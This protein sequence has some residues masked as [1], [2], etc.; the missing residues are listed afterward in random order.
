[1]ASVN[2]TDIVTRIQADLEGIQAL[3]DFNKNPLEA[4]MNEALNDSASE[5]DVSY[6]EQAGAG[7]DQMQAMTQLGLGSALN[8]LFGENS[9]SDVLQRW[10]EDNLRESAEVRTEMLEDVG[11]S[12]A[13]KW[14]VNTFLTQGPSTGLSI[15]ATSI[16][17]ILGFMVFGPPG[18]VAGAAGL[19]YLTN[20][21]LNAGENN[22]SQLM[23]LGVVDHDVALAAGATNAILDTIIPYKVGRIVSGKL[24]PKRGKFTEGFNKYVKKQIEEGSA[25]AS[26][27]GKGISWAL[28][29]G[30]TEGLQEAINEMFINYLKEEPI[31]DF[32]S[33]EWKHIREAAYAGGLVFGGPLG[34]LTG[35]KGKAAGDETAT[36]PPAPTT[37]AGFPVEPETDEDGRPIPRFYTDP[38]DGTNKRLPDT[39]ETQADRLKILN[40]LKYMEDSPVPSVPA[41]GD[42]VRFAGDDVLA[43]RLASL[44]QTEALDV[45]QDLTADQ[46]G[47]YFNLRDMGANHRQ[48]M[49][50]A[51]TGTTEFEGPI[52]PVTAGARGG[53]EEAASAIPDVGK[54]SPINEAIPTGNPPLDVSVGT[55]T[56]FPR[57]KEAMLGWN[58]RRRARKAAVEARQTA[59]EDA[60]RAEA[61]TDRAAQRERDTW[62][63][64][65]EMR[66][67][68]DTAVKE[69]AQTKRE[70]EAEF[71]ATE[72]RTKVKDAETQ[73]HEVY[74]M[75]E[76]D[77][78]FTIKQMRA[79]AAAE[80]T[81]FATKEEQAAAKAIF[82]WR[83]DVLDAK[84][85]QAAIMRGEEDEGIVAPEAAPT[86]TAEETTGGAAEAAAPTETQKQITATWKRLAE[87]KAKADQEAAT[88][89]EGDKAPTP[90]VTKGTVE[91]SSEGLGLVLLD[92]VDSHV[93]RYETIGDEPGRTFVLV[94]ITG[95][96]GNVIE[97]PFYISTGVGGKEET[98]PGKWYPVLGIGKADWINKTTG[99]ELADYYG[100]P[101]LREAAEK[102][103]ATL[104]DIRDTVEETVDGV[105]EA[106]VKA[107]LNASLEEIGTVII[108]KVYESGTVKIT[109]TEGRPDRISQGGKDDTPAINI[110]RSN[111]N[112]LKTALGVEETTGG[113][114]AP[115]VDVVTDPEE[116]VSATDETKAAQEAIAS[117]IDGD[118]HFS[119]AIDNLAEALGIENYDA[120]RLFGSTLN[121][122]QAGIITKKELDS[123]QTQE[124]QIQEMYDNDVAAA[125]TAGLERD[126][127]AALEKGREDKGTPEPPSTDAEIDASKKKTKKKT[128]KKKKGLK[129]AVGKEAKEGETKEDLVKF[130]DGEG[131]SVATISNTDSTVY[132]ND[133]GTYTAEFG[134]TIVPEPFATKA[135]AQNYLVTEH[136]TPDEIAN[137]KMSPIAGFT[138]KAR[139]KKA[140]KAAAKVDVTKA[141][142]KERGKFDKGEFE[143]NDNDVP[144]KFEDV[145]GSDDRIIYAELDGEPVL[146]GRRKNATSARGR[147]R[148]INLDAVRKV[149]RNLIKAREKAEAQAG[150]EAGVREAAVAAADV[151]TKRVATRSITPVSIINM[152]KRNIL[153]SN[154]SDQ[155]KKAIL[156]IGDTDQ[157]VTQK[158]DVAKAILGQDT[159]GYEVVVNYP[160]AGRQGTIRPFSMFIL[161]TRAAANAV[162]ES[163]VAQP[164]LFQ[165]FLVDS[166]RDRA[167]L[168]PAGAI[169]S[170]EVA[171]RIESRRNSIAE[172][173]R[174]ERRARRKGNS[175]S[176]E[177]LSRRDRYQRELDALMRE[178][179][180][181]GAG[182]IVPGDTVEDYNSSL[183]AWIAMLED[184]VTITGSTTRT[185]LI[186]KTIK[187]ALKLTEDEVET[188]EE[189]D[190]EGTMADE[191]AAVLGGIEEGQAAD[192]A[193]AAAK[194]NEEALK[195]EAD[196]A[197]K[198]S[199]FDK[200]KKDK[201]K[202]KE[203][204]EGVA[205]DNVIPI[206]RI[207]DRAEF[208]EALD[209]FDQNIRDPEDEDFAL[210]MM[211]QEEKAET[212]MAFLQEG[213]ERFPN[214][215]LPDSLILDNGVLRVS[216]DLVPA[217]EVVP[218]ETPT[219]IEGGLETEDASDLFLMEDMDAA[220]NEEI[221][222]Q[223]REEAQD[224]LDKKNKTTADKLNP[225]AI[226]LEDSATLAADLSRTTDRGGYSATQVRQLAA[227]I[228]KAFPEFEYNP[229]S[230][231]SEISQSVMSWHVA[232]TTAEADAVG[233]AGKFETTENEE[234][235]KS[236]RLKDVDWDTR[237]IIRTR[238]DAKRSLRR[239]LNNIFG[240][241]AVQRMERIGFINIINTYRDTEWSAGLDD[242]AFVT[243]DRGQV[244][245]I[246]DGIKDKLPRTELRG[247]ILHEIGVHVGRDLFTGREWAQILDEVYKL[248]LEGNEAVRAAVKKV[249][250]NYPDE[251][252][253]DST[254]RPL[255]KFDDS[256]KFNLQFTKPF[257]W[258][259]GE[260]KTGELFRTAGR[261]WL[262]GGH[263]EEFKERKR[264]WEEV[265]AHVIDGD[266]YKV[267][268][269]NASKSKSF[270]KK[271]KEAFNKFF[272]KV[273]TNFGGDYQSETANV[274]IDDV[275]S[276]IGYAITHAPTLALARHGDPKAI[277][278][279][280]NLTRK[281]FLENSQEKEVQYHGTRDSWSHPLIDETELGLH[282]GT[283]V[284]AINIHR[285][286]HWTK[287]AP[288]RGPRELLE[289][290]G[291]S[292]V[293]IDIFEPGWESKL[294]DRD[295]ANVI[296]NWK[297]PM[298][299][300]SYHATDVVQTLVKRGTVIKAGYVKVENPL[301]IDDD[302]G[303]W[304]A[305]EA[306][307]G[308][309]K[310]WLDEQGRQ[311]PAKELEASPLWSMFQA[312]NELSTLYDIKFLKALQMPDP[313]HTIDS[314]NKRE[315]MTDEK[316]E[317]I[318]NVPR[319]FQ[320]KLKE[321]I[322]KNGYDSIAY[323]NGI[324]DQG[325]T[326]YIL[327]DANQFM[328]V[329][330]LT[331]KSGIS[332]F[333][334]KKVITGSYE[335]ELTYAKKISDVATEETAKTVIGNAKQFSVIRFLQ[336]LVE[337]LMTVEGYDQLET[338]RMLTKGKIGQW[339]TTGRIL[340]DIM[341]TATT[342]E[343]KIITKFFTTRGASPSMLPD[344]QV[345]VATRRTILKG[346]RPG[347]QRNTR[348]VSLRDEVVK[349]KKMISDLGKEL[350]S[351]GMITK[352]QYA[353]W[354]NKYLP[355]IYLKNVLSGA[356]RMGLGF[357]SSPL[358][359]T[360]QRK[361]ERFL[362]DIIE[363]RIDDPALLASRYIQMAGS[364]IAVM[365][366][367]EFIVS[368]PGNNGWVLPGQ[369]IKVRGMSGTAPY[370]AELADAMSTRADLIDKYDS[371]KANQA[372]KLAKEMRIKADAAM[373]D[374]RGV[375]M[376][377]YRQ[378][379]KSERYGQMQGLWVMKDIWNDI[380][381]NSG[382]G[383]NSVIMEMFR[384]AQTG[385]KYTHVPLNIPTQFRN[386]GSN[387]ILMDT[388]GTNFLKIPGLLSKAVV[389]I[390]HNGKYHQIAQKYGL[391]TTTFAS[392][393]LLRIDKE[394]AKVQ[395]KE[396][397]IM[398][399]MAKGKI[400]FDNYIDIGGRT[401]QASEVLFKTAKIMDLM[402][403]HGKTEAEAARLANEALIDYSNVSV[404]IRALRSL[405]LGSPF[406]TFNAKVTAQLVRNF[407]NHPLSFAKYVALPW[408]VREWVLS[409]NDDLD[410]EDLDDLKKFLHKHM[411]E[412]KGT[413]VMPTKDHNG[414][415]QVIPFN[416]FAPWGF[417]LNFYN[418]TRGLFVEDEEARVGEALM[419]D[420][421]I[422][423][424]PAEI[425]FGLA[426]NV[427]PFTGHEIWN[428]FDPPTQQYQDITA[429]LASYFV[430]PMLM[431]RNRAGDIVKGG[432]PLVKTMMAYNYIE[433]N[434]GQDGLPKYTIPQALLSWMGVNITTV[435][436]HDAMAKAY[437]SWKEVENIQRRLL[438]IITDPSLR[439]QPSRRLELIQ[440]YQELMLNKSLEAQE[441][442][443]ALN[444]MDKLFNEAKASRD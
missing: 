256:Q 386:V 234:G 215:T 196:E 401:Y 207:T 223:E 227:N 321:L 51:I 85:R 293:E 107:Q 404:G 247:L 50:G 16:G 114:P 372:R 140:T 392:E 46:Q 64:N 429:Y 181:P 323:V 280:R 233:D 66:Q 78:G 260:T 316:A 306:W 214:V 185:P 61:T 128:T 287:G 182:V 156:S 179:N 270:I 14:W 74:D 272:N 396:N 326:S 343:R 170:E 81:K 230:V 240:S 331:F 62:F 41:T 162:R 97:V 444:K 136:G 150:K 43:V 346:D 397:S 300:K 278:K 258:E 144:I 175:I 115:T 249:I 13:G 409:E 133:D 54:V 354:E 188:T 376:S 253:R 145:R 368:D 209:T 55:E 265:L 40:Q 146:M 437:Y 298:T 123:D 246:A 88:R 328:P 390:F 284:V 407:K 299:F 325:S 42:T 322:L 416:Y 307:K 375:D 442:S 283:P 303:S 231:K 178:E 408:I 356:D 22:A 197:A 139:K 335:E 4:S 263:L 92:G 295:L 423:S 69:D 47:T 119:D 148:E 226:L 225:M 137:W 254:G 330:S 384:Y 12:N 363:G 364:D 351:M 410:E 211:E 59:Q 387:F 320:K 104:G 89:E 131:M 110:L 301:H 82:K 187:D 52:P 406:I 113:Q 160:R 255:Y 302:I 174:K 177:E 198:Q 58:Q 395:A 191:K 415:W 159:E 279:L 7:F 189:Y 432:G 103:D 76:N 439:G 6:V 213:V 252:W 118:V 262:I 124:E 405:P 341:D 422:L 441:I 18:A 63:N 370:F 313:P 30:G 224:L 358:N 244:F 248:N 309:T 172:I 190:F 48:A 9:V 125:E 436:R 8:S 271:I 27:L 232:E 371:V 421:G 163:I 120:A 126:E 347:A 428:E 169:S 106:Q 349:A 2:S 334:D 219:T 312:I 305:P 108:P 414:K 389:D 431:P 210:S 87:L 388:S 352:E 96:N 101:E 80:V 100:I 132:T 269:K 203:E 65:V 250:A 400:F 72:L 121:E 166:I 34:F 221:A 11:I 419:K 324:E 218:F 112:V 122:E 184:R 180:R 168:A 264:F 310:R 336:R 241:K 340:F 277:R 338:Q 109:K 267:Y 329:D 427:D 35:G 292:P 420:T 56:R 367:L 138:D 167:M 332:P 127:A 315:L 75:L 116:A 366:Y 141:K 274:T 402:E 71:D 311:G 440:Q 243:P 201:D 183:D 194:R 199:A 314:P 44:E 157:P 102:L 251:Q 339:A 49:K 28:V 379:P 261:E 362:Q 143:L 158:A 53:P 360:K 135:Q 374:F 93:I 355:R 359:Y 308:F 291:I 228:K 443:D 412:N 398:G 430:P 235:F 289:D 220:I 200:R 68:L 382:L 296:L 173:D 245:F 317:A 288:R 86:G 238:N 357:K 95:P 318:F 433:G 154:R 26:R 236:T 273:I 222:R 24:I 77:G 399:M 217:G 94:K 161:K 111:L 1:M 193:A 276:L 257:E 39:P 344:K 36:E 38:I 304:S 60:D 90:T 212:Y 434:V 176:E 15:A 208:E 165:E 83:I 70:L 129:K 380:Q 393:E 216:R 411:A 282:V 229:K 297:T 426:Q 378:V 23:E 345:D 205:A 3:R 91:E 319:E 99:A 333:R 365:K 195:A 5:D 142:K 294:T 377:K 350:V 391:E 84:Q 204:S 21:L 285:L 10:G 348:T 342:A 286:G 147:A 268:P 413:L 19:G 290:E 31:A 79:Y 202:K 117:V 151:E 327:F 164:S 275:R 435:G 149:Q 130:V 373:P 242:V 353:E 25:L 239:E 134:S 186:V 153:P 417:W 361:H 259:E 381:G 237:G 105:A 171:R 192:R 20:T 57:T 281:R 394:L 67:R 98:T 385:F 155:G 152:I 29:E 425:G 337:P 32:T 73:A 266:P 33:D 45:S 17:G 403:N 438:K 383:G 206:A 369:V 418:N 37:I 424:G